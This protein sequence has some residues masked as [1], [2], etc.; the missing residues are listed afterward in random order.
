MDHFVGDDTIK[1]SLMYSGFL[2]DE[3]FGPLH[4]SLTESKPNSCS[5]KSAHLVAKSKPNPNK[6]HIPSYNPPPK[7]SKYSLDKANFSGDWGNHSK[8][9]YDQGPYGSRKPEGVFHRGGKN[10]RKP[11]GRGKRGSK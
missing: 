10:N 2:S 7:R 8:S 9:A 4:K 3:L 11:R 1:E 6:R 5:G